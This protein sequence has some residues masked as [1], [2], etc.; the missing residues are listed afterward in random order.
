MTGYSVAI[1]GATGLVGTTLLSLL[2]ERG[3]PAKKLYLIASQQSAGKALTFRQETHPIH[4]LATF[5][6]RQ[7]DITFFCVGNHLSAQYVPQAISC[8][9][10][11]IDK[12][13]YFRNQADIPL[14][15]PEVN[16]HILDRYQQ[17]NLIA[18][19]NCMALPIAVALKPIYDAVGI[20]RINVATYQS[21]SGTGKEA[22]S[23]LTQQTAQ[24]LS[25]QP[26]RSKVYSQQ[27]AFNVLPHIDDFQ[28]N[29][30]TGEEMKIVSELQKIFDDPSLAVNPTAVRVPVFCGHAAAVHIET[31]DK[32]TVERALQLLAGAPSVKLITGEYPYPT[33]VQ[34]AAGKDYVCV[35][36]IRED[37]S[38]G[39]G[40]N[41]WIVADNLRKGAAL[42]AVQIA[43]HL[44]KHYLSP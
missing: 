43:E 37:I 8:G 14:L 3:F 22:V 12:S 20:E 42:N 2:E 6:F 21:V 28:V 15:V 35:G 13:S 7:T 39:K 18:N 19:P 30:Y 10:I 36:R 31:K 33:P 9:N 41:L 26:V 38:C 44:I 40:L 4:D 23:E 29:G 1:V 24:L 25:D 17:K 11:V 5:D 32:I 27:I 34:D 16:I